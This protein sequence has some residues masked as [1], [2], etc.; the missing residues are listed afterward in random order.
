MNV[1]ESAKKTIDKLPKEVSIDDIIN[2]LYINA[3][4]GH[5]ENEIREGKGIS[6]NEAKQRLQK[7][8][9]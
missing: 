5:G 2:A 9:R 8:V 6:H 4:F 7:W 3:K 1:K